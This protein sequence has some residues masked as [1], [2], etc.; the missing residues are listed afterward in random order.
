MG[1]VQPAKPVAQRPKVR[2]TA[3]EEPQDGLP[4]PS[5]GTRNAR[6]RRFCRRCA[7]PLSQ[8]APVAPLPW[9][10][11]VWP[12]RRK[13][14]A[15]SG[16]FLRRLIIV[17]VLVGLVVGGYF[18][19]PA[20]RWVYEDVRDK[21]G[22]ATPTTPTSVAA[23]A[24]APGHGAALATDGLSNTY[25]G[26][27]ALDDSMTFT[28]R[29]PF[30]L[31]A[32][33]IHTGVS[34]KPETFRNQ[35]RPTKADLVVTSSDGRIHRK[36]VTLADKPGPQTIQTGYSDVVSIQ[37]TPRETAGFSKGRHIAVAEVEFFK[38]S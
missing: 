4:C 12:F 13:V 33:V 38:R 36:T 8:A 20:G 19:I 35:A 7:T 37:L 18:L 29:S 27:P 21:L 31:V 2:P 24:S 6:G 32:V 28:F 17:L 16:Q 15:G 22:K 3:S 30:R 11:T 25:W 14:R 26:A 1:A 23:D 34:K 10:R 5:C 9:W